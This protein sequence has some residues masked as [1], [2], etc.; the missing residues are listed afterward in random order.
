MVSFKRFHNG[1]KPLSRRAYVIMTVAF[2]LY[3]LLWFSLIIYFSFHWGELSGFYRL[4]LFIV[5][6]ILMP[7]KKELVTS[8]DEYLKE[9]ERTKH[10]R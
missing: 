7:S 8:Y 6:G 2:W 5:I 3:T 4:L 9:F 1:I 10:I